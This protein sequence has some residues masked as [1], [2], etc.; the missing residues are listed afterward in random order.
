M[1]KTNILLSRFVAYWFI[2]IFFSLLSNCYAINLTSDEKAYLHSKKNIIFVSQSHYPPFE[3]VD[4]NH[5]VQGMM[6]DLI[7]WMAVEMSFRP[8]FKTMTFE[9]AQDDVLSG[10]AD[11]ITSLFYS[12]KRSKK[13]QFTNT[14]FDVP[15]SIFVKKGRTDIKDIKDLNGKTIAIQNGDY[16]KDY[17]E[18]HNVHF[19]VIN[20][21]DFSEATDKVIDNE[22]DAVIGDEPIVLYH[23]FS[24]HLTDYIQKMDTPLYIGKNCMA[25]KKGNTL[26][27][28]ILN[29]GIEQA[30][31]DGV[32]DKISRKWL[33]IT[34]G[35]K[36]SFVERYLWQ[37]SAAVTGLLLLL[38]GVWV[39]NVR[40]RFLVREKTAVIVRREEALRESE[41]NFRTF[42]TTMDDVIL[43][44]APDGAILYT[45]PVV[46][47]KLGYGIAELAEMNIFDLHPQESRQEMEKT[48]A[49][50]LKGELSHCPLPLQTKTGV[51]IPVESRAW[52]GKWND[53]DCIFCISKDLTKEQEALQ[54]FNLLF[55]SNPALMAVMSATEKRFTEI[56]DA[57]V[58]AL[59]FSREKIIDKTFLEL[60]LF[61][62]PESFHS[63]IDVLENDGRIGEY[64]EL[65]VRSQDGKILDEIISGGIIDTQ[66]QKYILI[67]MVDQT[68]RKQMERELRDSE[69][70][71]RSIFDNS[72]DG[73]IFSDP[74]GSIFAA[75]RAATEILGWTEEEICQGGRQLLVDDDDPKLLKAIT[76][77]NNTGRFRGELFFRRKN[78]EKFPVELSSSLF[79]LGNGTPRASIIFRDISDRKAA[80]DSL[81][82]IMREQQVILDNASI[83]ISMTI[84]KVQIWANRKLRE[85]FQYSPEEMEGLDTRKLLPSLEAFDLFSKTARPV[86]AQ[87]EIYQSEQ[88]LIR[89]DGSPFFVKIVGKAIT[90][91]D[92]SQG[93]IW[94][95][96]D[97]TEQKKMEEERRQWERQRQQQQKTQSLNRMAGAIAHL[98]NNI[99]STVIGNLEMAVSEVPSSHSNGTLQEALKAS[100][101]AS[102]VSSLMLTYLGQSIA[103]QETKDLSDVCRESLPILESIPSKHVVFNVDFPTPGP[104]ININES[105][106]RQVLK[107]LVT[108]AV[109]TLEKNGGT[110]SL[111]ICN[112]IFAKD[113]PSVHRFPVGWVAHDTSYACIEV[114]DTGS[115]VG[116]KEIEQIF[117]PFYS[118]KFT[119]RGLGLPVVLG[120]VRAHNGVITVESLPD[121]GST[122]RV[123]LPLSPK[124]S[125]ADPTN[126]KNS[127]SPVEKNNTILLVEAEESLRRLT[128]TM[129][130][131]LNYKVHEA[132]EGAQAM[133]IFRRHQQTISLVICGLTIPG[134]DGLET[135]EVLHKLAPNL[136]VILTGDDQEMQIINKRRSERPWAFLSKPYG[137]SELSDIVTK[138]VIKEDT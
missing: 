58:N 59:G 84:G 125:L 21:K 135:C 51:L 63:I 29:K 73:V 70:R 90:P 97:I 92:M 40:L 28:D 124:K 119:G 108:N 115:G 26:L 83:G 128:A 112:S 55:N 64:Q 32:L 121:K 19:S 76:E 126:P 8:V 89:K 114:R 136:P 6:I 37:I 133:E 48:I 117:D 12:E 96:E 91:S 113:I 110:V 80:E 78:G 66:G 79:S 100:Y 102:E 104:L 81:T 87:G 57:F 22:A 34:F 86:L 134:L 120:I 68:K 95:H 105:Q 43:V 98:F 61:V 16:A 44:G 71:F 1:A 131:R 23:I 103:D 4:A 75:N 45:N 5:Q 24:K 101:R 33:G 62:H 69:E 54:K 60:D 116:D 53:K 46:I 47:E 36:E 77:R 35:H 42:F 56:N 127:S 132:K 13:F 72:S 94:T 137:F 2:F 38:L 11:I 123:F 67:V 18:S 82:K 106:I 107:N 122:F 25:A 7:H 14:L 138:Y 30:R 50:L 74:K 41:K 99:L 109:E 31:K 9:Q 85:L 88:T 10:R 65:Q 39:W 3:F 49:S 52:S 118:T 15:A 111:T 17:L 129:L 20:T 93:I 130:K 27:I